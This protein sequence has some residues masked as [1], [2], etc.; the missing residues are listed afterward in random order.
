[1]KILNVKKGIG[2]LVLAAS[3]ALAAMSQKNVVFIIA[4]D[5]NDSIA[6]LGGHPQAVTPN[7]DRLAEM[8]VRFTNAQSNSPM[9]AP[10]RPSLLSGL[11]PHRTGMVAGKPRF[12]TLPLLKDAV[13]FPS[14]LKE[15]G[16]QCYSGG[17][18]FHG[19]DKDNTVFGASGPN[20]FDG[21]YIGPIANFGPYPWDGKTMLWGRPSREVLN[22]N[23]PWF[24]KKNWPYGFGRLSELPPGNTC[25]AY[26]DGGFKGADGKNGGV[27]RYENTNDRSPM[28]D[29]IIAEWGVD[30]LS[31]RKTSALNKN[32]K[33]SRTIP[34]GE[35]PFFLGLGFIKTHFALY[36]PDEFY[37][38]VLKANGITED[39][40]AL[41]WTRNGQIQFNDLDD[42]PKDLRGD[43]SAGRKRYKVMQEA[44]THH[45]GGLEGLL[46]EVTLAYL[47][48]VYEVD[49]QV[50]KILDALEES[51]R[52]EN[53]IIIFTSDHGYNHGDK[54][55]FFKYLLWE[56]SARVPF[57]VYDP[58]SEFDAGRGKDCAAPVSL[59][60]LYPTLVDLCGLDTKDGLDGHS[61]RPLLRNPVAE[62]WEGPPVALTTIKGKSSNLF[63]VRSKR[64][65]YSLGEQGGEELYDHQNDSWE[66][67]NLAANLEYAEIKRDLKAELKKLTDQ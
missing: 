17:K 57:I 16:Y 41:P 36:S 1:M 50:G 64:Y 23:Y 19:I 13:L 15:N 58:S 37:D 51:G 63:S 2:V 61:I 43:Y 49:V 45:E 48:A 27:F 66:W 8:G 35:D 60:D 22:P 33:P 3:A 42:I 24:G 18:I 30:L 4:D 29:E 9:C 6:G 59:I 67:T 14:Y 39:E 25:W 21:G 40:V 11:Y 53:T 62:S 32:L 54:E 47:A 26:C 56:K 55:S 44:G 46:K 28:P 38:A 31:G 10:S 34:L 65:R 5:L 7:L 52:L 20:K 12:R